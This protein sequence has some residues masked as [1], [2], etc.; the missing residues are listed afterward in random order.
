MCFPEM[1]LIF[2][3]FLTERRNSKLKIIKTIQSGLS[4]RFSEYADVFHQQVSPIDALSSCPLNNHGSAPVIPLSLV[5]LRTAH[6]R[7]SGNSI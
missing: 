4:I 7:N 6:A 5:K 1:V 3:L 2:Q